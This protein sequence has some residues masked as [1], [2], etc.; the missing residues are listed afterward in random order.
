MAD[1][2]VGI[3]LMTINIT[4]HTNKVLTAVMVAIGSIL[5]APMCICALKEDS[6]SE[7]I[8]LIQWG[9]Q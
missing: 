9:G 5:M 2:I 7:G 3:T 6:T 1:R 4:R 8:F